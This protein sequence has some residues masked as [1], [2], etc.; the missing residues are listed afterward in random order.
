MPQLLE[1]YFVVILLS[2]LLCGYGISMKMVYSCFLIAYEITM[3]LSVT[4][5][6]TQLYRAILGG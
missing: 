1:L 4:L 6:Q 5:V 3:P 2:L